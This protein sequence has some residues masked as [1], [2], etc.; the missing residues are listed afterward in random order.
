MVGRSIQA[1]LVSNERV[2]DKNLKAPAKCSVS[3][4]GTP[5]PQHFE[6]PH[7]P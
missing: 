7:L 1:I 4:N 2:V 6:I 5:R 3:D